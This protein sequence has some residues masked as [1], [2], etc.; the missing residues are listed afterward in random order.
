MDY[1]LPVNKE[2]VRKELLKMV[3]DKMDAMPMT[4]A[5]VLTPLELD[6]IWTVHPTTNDPILM[7]SKYGAI[8]IWFKF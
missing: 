3:A 1:T 5:H 8:A 6:K 2:E 4:L 7:S